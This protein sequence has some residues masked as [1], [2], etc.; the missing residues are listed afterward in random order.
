MGEGGVKPCTAR[1][2]TTLQAR[3]FYNACMLGLVVPYLL[4]KSVHGVLVQRRHQLQ[5]LAKARDACGSNMQPCERA[6]KCEY[7]LQSALTAA[8]AAR[9][10]SFSLNATAVHRLCNTPTSSGA[11]QRLQLQCMRQPGCV[12]C[13]AARSAR[14]CATRH[15]PPRTS[16]SSVIR[17]LVPRLHTTRHFFTAAGSDS[18]RST[19]T[20][21]RNLSAALP[22]LGAR[23]LLR[24]ASMF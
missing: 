20:S 3:A 16:A 18:R 9:A 17:S 23:P 24:R 14:R 5:R 13:T 2:R 21:K 15:S 12:Q 8:W 22:D 10:G 7:K 1:V 19:Q 4:L 11:A 6:F